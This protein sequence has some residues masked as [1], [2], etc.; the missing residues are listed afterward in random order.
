MMANYRWR[1]LSKEP[2]ATRPS[3]GCCSVIHRHSELTSDILETDIVLAGSAVWS[4]DYCVIHGESGAKTVI[5]DHVS[6]DAEIRPAYGKGD[7]MAL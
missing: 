2:K 5:L 6:R 7:G 1:S 3:S 4:S